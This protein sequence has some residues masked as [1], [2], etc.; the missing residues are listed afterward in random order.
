LSLV[1]GTPT[2]NLHLAFPTDDDAGVQRFH[3]GCDRRRLRQQ[4]G[5]RRTPAL[6]PRL[7]RRHVLDAGGNNIEVVHHHLA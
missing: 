2:E 6:P 4:R 7:L 3:A 5:T 1:N